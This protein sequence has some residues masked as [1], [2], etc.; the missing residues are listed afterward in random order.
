MLTIAVLTGRRPA[1]LKQTLEAFERH[2][3][4]VW[5]DA[6]RVVVHNTG[7]VETAEVLDGYEWDAR[8]VLDGELRSIAQAS[9]HL[10]ELAAQADQ[11]YV[12][13]LEDD[14]EALP[15]P[16]YDDAVRLLDEI[17]GQVRLRAYDE[18]VLAQHRITKQRIV[19]TT[20]ADGHRV[21]RSAHYTHNPSLMRT[22]DLVAMSGYDDEIDAAR[23]FLDAGH[24]TSQHVPGAFRHLGDR[25]AGLSLKW[26]EGRS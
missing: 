15:V 21:T 26:S 10:I 7:D 23:R 2:H 20:R 22:W 13:R 3:P 17:G 11:R 25:A 19:W 24:A 6:T 9:L 4:D 8:R 1:L 5:H 18:R 12:L 14:W 16:F